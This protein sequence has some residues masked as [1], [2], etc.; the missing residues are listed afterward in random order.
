VQKLFFPQ[1]SFLFMFF[2]GGGKGLCTNP[3]SLLK[4]NKSVGG[5]EVGWV[6]AHSF[7]VFGGLGGEYKSIFSLFLIG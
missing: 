5:G 4:K 3:L 7:L 2:W 6:E 1:S